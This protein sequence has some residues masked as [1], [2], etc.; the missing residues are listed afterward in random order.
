MSPLEIFNFRKTKELDSWEVTDDVVMGGKSNSHF[1]INSERK[2]I[3]QGKVSTEN[4]GGFSSVRYRFNPIRVEGLLKVK[5]K[6]KGDNQRFQFRLK[7]KQTDDH[8]YIQYFETNG[9]WQ[10]I[11]IELNNLYPTYRGNKLDKPNF[12]GNYIEEI[13][14]LIGNNKNEEFRL[15]IDSIYLI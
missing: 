15:E 2:G 5:L 4:N 12:K 3:F 8:S 7:E 13:G 9:E 10:E 11:E 6:V 1:S 14:F